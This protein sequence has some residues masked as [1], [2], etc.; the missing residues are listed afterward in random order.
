MIEKYTHTHNIQGHPYN[1]FEP[2]LFNNIKD[3]QVV[4]KIHFKN[5]FDFD[6]ATF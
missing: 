2:N 3:I 1:V 5:E 4:W 6:K